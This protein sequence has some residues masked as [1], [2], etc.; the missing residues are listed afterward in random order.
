MTAGTTPATP[1]TE[2]PVPPL[3]L[4]VRDMDRLGRIEQA[5]AILYPNGGDLA[6]VRLALAEAGIPAPPTE[7]VFEF[8][9]GME[10]YG[11]KQKLGAFAEPVPGNLYV[12]LGPDKEPVSVGIV[13]KL[14]GDKGTGGIIRDRFYRAATADREVQAAQ[15]DGWLLSPQGCAPCMDRKRPRTAPKAG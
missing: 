8:I 3:A 6:V 7:D 1:A 2:P 10:R 15:V 9:Q 14:V 12:I 5:A 13:A 4:V 11:Y